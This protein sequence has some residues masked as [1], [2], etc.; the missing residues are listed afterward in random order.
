MILT[1]LPAVRR[2]AGPGRADRGSVALELAVV[3][4]A[5]LGLLLLIVGA[6]RVALAGQSV[7]QAAAQ[8]AR[9][10][11]MAR[12]PTAGS[13]AG[14]A[15]AAQALSTQGLHCQPATVTVSTGDLA[16]AAG[17]AG[18]V[19]VAVSCRVKLSDLAV[20]GLPG[21]KTLRADMTM[22]IDTYVV[23]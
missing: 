13:A 21:S 22:P 1:S 17:E 7:Q 8:G 9:A 5:F 19:R 20:P 2:L 23:R 3:T 11:S 6:G 15:T 14:K 10:A 12:T 18:T 16:G 4:P